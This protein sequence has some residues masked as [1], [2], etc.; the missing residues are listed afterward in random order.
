MSQ[1]VQ[2]SGVF[3]VSNKTSPASEMILE[4]YLKKCVT[5]TTSKP[6]NPKVNLKAVRT[7][8]SPF[9]DFPKEMMPKKGAIEEPEPIDGY[10]TSIAITGNSKHLCLL[11]RRWQIK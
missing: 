1:G 8:H 4:E 10:A 7:Q 11:G 5:M 9:G 3:F 6:F 2:Q